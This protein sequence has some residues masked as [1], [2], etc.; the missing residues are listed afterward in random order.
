MASESLTRMRKSGSKSRLSSA[1][2]RRVA[3]GGRE[4]IDHPPGQHDD[5]VNS[6]AGALVNVMAVSANDRWATFPKLLASTV[7]RTEVDIDDPLPV[8]SKPWRPDAAV[9]AAPPA[10]R[11]P[12]V[13]DGFLELQRIAREAASGGPAMQKAP[14]CASCRKPIAGPHQSDGALAWCGR[15]CEAAWSAARLARASALAPPVQGA[16]DNPRAATRYA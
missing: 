5:V 6:A 15:A 3:R 2:E 9:A 4:S 11:E 13:L 10:P 7:A 14:V 8:N 1:G 12:T 16:A